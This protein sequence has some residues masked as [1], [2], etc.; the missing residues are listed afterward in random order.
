MTASFDL[1]IIFKMEASNA[2][3][4]WTIEL[5]GD[6]TLLPNVQATELEG[7]VTPGRLEKI[8][9]NLRLQLTAL[10]KSGKPGIK[11]VYQ[12]RAKQIAER[13]KQN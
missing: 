1:L 11:G 6:A 8:S 4:S 2:G 9:A 13:A 3:E 5:D 7:V 10:Q 12:A